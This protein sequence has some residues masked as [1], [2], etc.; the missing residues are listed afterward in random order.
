MQP[1]SQSAMDYGLSAQAKER[2][3]HGFRSDPFCPAVGERIASRLFGILFRQFG[4]EAGVSNPRRAAD[5][6]EITLQLAYEQNPAHGLLQEIRDFMDLVHY[7]ELYRNVASRHSKRQRQQASM[8]PMMMPN[9][10]PQPAESLS[11]EEASPAAPAAAPAPAV[12]PAPAQP[13]DPSPTPITRSYS[14]VKQ[15]P[16]KHLQQTVFELVEELGASWTADLSVTGLL[17]I[18]YI[19]SRVKPFTPL[20][21]LRALSQSDI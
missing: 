9:M 6:L 15:I 5:L 18:I 13:E 19:C 16:R 8:F 10:F 14:M 20:T 17:A 7:L 4:K 3:H 12:A 2:L 11:S 1:A 21:Q